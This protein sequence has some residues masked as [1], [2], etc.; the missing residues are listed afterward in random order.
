MI[1]GISKLQ[2]YRWFTP[3]NHEIMYSQSPPYYYS[4]LCSVVVDE[5]LVCSKN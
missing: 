3:L 2:V 5:R 1:D 4:V